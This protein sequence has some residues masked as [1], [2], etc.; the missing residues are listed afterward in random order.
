M[1]HHPSSP[2]AFVSRDQA[3]ASASESPE[4]IADAAAGAPPSNTAPANSTSPVAKVLRT[5]IDSLYVSFEGELRPKWDLRLKE[6]KQAAQS[7]IEAEKLEAQ[8]E[9]GGHRFEVG[10]KGRPHYAYVIRD[11]WFSISLAASSAEAMPVAYVQI[12]SETLVLEGLP[13][14]IEALVPI[15]KTMAIVEGAPR[16]SRVDICA[17]F[18]TDFDIES[19]TRKHWISRARTLAQYMSNYD[20]SGWTIGKGSPM[21]A[22]LY[23]KTLELQKSQKWYMEG[24]WIDCGWPGGAKVWRLEFEVHQERLSELGLLT[25]EHLSE[26]LQSLWIYCSTDWLRLAVPSPDDQTRSRW[27]THPLWIALTEATFSGQFTGSLRRARKE[28][29][30]SDEHLFV[31]GLGGLTSYMAVRGITDIEEGVAAFLVDATKFHGQHG[32]PLA[33]YAQ[34]K[35]LQ[36]GRRFN[37]MSTRTKGWPDDLTTATGIEAVGDAEA[38][39]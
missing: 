29:V 18:T 21:M 35:V 27:P 10:D 39:E 3:A 33:I 31:H 17:D 15:I 6:L 12:S 2:S 5:G 4:A 13:K 7:D 26:C 25:V 32:K 8:V 19:L 24:V 1:E 9:I 38:R 20:L 11:N 28:R 30:P 14:A 36:K 23:D 34:E 16:V 22:R 37:T